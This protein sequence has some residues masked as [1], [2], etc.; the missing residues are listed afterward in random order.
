MHD[1]GGVRRCGT[2]RWTD[3]LDQK[4]KKHR[5]NETCMYAVYRDVMVLQSCGATQASCGTCL[6]LNA[7]MIQNTNASATKQCKFGTTPEHR[8]TAGYARATA[9]VRTIAP[10]TLSTPTL[11]VIV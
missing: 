11:L 4:K 10:S 5:R 2:D 1:G 9:V 7:A 3:G 8:A 6:F